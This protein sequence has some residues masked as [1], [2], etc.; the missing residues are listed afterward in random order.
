MTIHNLYEKIVLALS[1]L[2]LNNLILI[3]I[4]FPEFILKINILLFLFILLFFYFY[5]PKENL[6]LKI[7][8][9]LILLI[10]LGTPTFEWDPRSIWLFHAKRIFYDNS[11]FSFAD[12]YAAFSHNDY[13][14]LVPALAS[15][16][17]TLLGHWNEVFPKVAFTLMFFP[18]LLISYIFFKDI[19][20]LIFLSLVLF[21][22][23][24]YL[25][26]GWADGLVAVYF[27]VS[28]LLMYFLLV[29]D[30]NFYKKNKIYYLIAFC[31]FITLTLIKNEGFALLFILF[32]STFFINIYK[33][34]ISKNFKKLIYLSS[35]FIPILLWKYFCYLNGIGN[36]YVNSDIFVNLLPRIS[37]YENYFLIF[38][39]L[40]LNEK[41][42]FALTFFLIV[43]W[44]KKDK[45][46]FIF[47]F[48]NAII[49]ILVLFL[50]FLS[51]PLDFYFQLDS[52]AARVIKTV[53]FLLAF[54][55]LYNLSI[56][57][58]NFF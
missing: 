21:F 24:K 1:L 41:F 4:N 40:L 56:T 33:K 11:I 52:T 9:I 35:C 13:P 58:R 48:L 14:N 15:S 22:I 5:K 44:I 38:Y 42:L 18:P 46:L 19:K 45:E 51:T 47:V 17:A 55:G 29:D 34:K 7:F 2:I 16:L 30:N 28:S 37:N 49:Y 10:S 57:K 12:N 43:F 50:I 20:Y 25:F 23:G 31:F 27:G 36:D 8:F 6:Y 39:Y 54:F 53:S 3:G 32:I 26:T